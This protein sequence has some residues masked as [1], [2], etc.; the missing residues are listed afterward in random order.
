MRGETTYEMSFLHFRPYLPLLLLRIMQTYGDYISLS[1]FL[2]TLYAFQFDSTAGWGILIS[3]AP[4]YGDERRWLASILVFQ[5]C[6]LLLLAWMW[7]VFQKTM[8]A[9]DLTVTFAMVIEFLP[10]WGLIRGTYL[11]YSLI[12]RRRRVTSY[13]FAAVF[14]MTIGL[15]QWRGV[16]IMRFSTLLSSLIYTDSYAILW[17]LTLGYTVLFLNPD[18]KD[19]SS[20]IPA[21]FQQI[22]P[23]IEFSFASSL[24]LSVPSMWLLL[25]EDMY[26]PVVILLPPL[27]SAILLQLLLTG[28]YISKGVVDPISIS[29]SSTNSGRGFCRICHKTILRRLRSKHSSEFATHHETN[30]SLKTSAIEGCRIC[31]HVWCRLTRLKPQRVCIMFGPIT[32]FY[33]LDLRISII[34]KVAPS[35]TFDFEIIPLSNV[36]TNLENHTGSESSLGTAKQWLSTCMQNHPSCSAGSDTHFRPS[37]LLYIGGNANQVI[38]HTPM[39]YPEMLSYMTLSH[40]WGEA[41]FI[42]LR[43]SDEQTFRQGIPWSSLPQTFKDAVRVARHLGSNYL[44]IDSLCIVQD[45]SRDWVAEA[46]SMGNIYKNALCNIAASDALNSLE[47]CLYPRNYRGLVPERLVWNSPLYLVNAPSMRPHEVPQLYSRAWV[48]QEF[49]L[50][51]RTLD[52]GRDQLYW[53]CDELMASEEFPIPSEIP[54]NNYFYSN[55]KFTHPA[56]EVLSDQADNAN[57]KLMVARMKEWE[58]DCHQHNP[59]ENPIGKP[60]RKYGMTGSPSIFWSKLVA[61]YSTMSITKEEDRLTAIAGV[62]DAFRPFLGEYYAGMWQYLLPQYLLWSNMPEG[63]FYSTQSSCKRPSS[64]RGPTWSWIALEGPI[65]HRSWAINWDDVMLSHVLDVKIVSAQEIHLRIRAP[66]IRLKRNDYIRRGMAAL[67]LKSVN[68]GPS[69]KSRGEVSNKWRSSWFEPCVHSNKDTHGSLILIFDVAEEE[70][71]ARDIVLVA[72]SRGDNSVNG[73]IPHDNG[74]GVFTRS[75]RPVKGLILQDKGGGFFTR[76]GVF[77][78]DECSCF[79]QTFLNCDQV[80]VV[81]L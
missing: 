51:R 81:L 77:Q 33:I 60:F 38:L 44:W 20:T 56:R 70:A 36:S 65:C 11:L 67:G 74:G 45:S 41:Q 37:R 63:G 13:A 80:E 4:I 53:R 39:D 61:Q 9:R 50:A 21:I 59:F 24:L 75:G 15:L 71:A 69:I 30:E 48:F 8:S 6:Q 68:S 35:A 54:R 26:Y 58:A 31:A 14:M 25:Q 3:S 46:A 28:H 10:P 32:R 66:L 27:S 16:R 19:A 43:Q 78:T 1:I 62:A 47:G 12:S 76:V 34:H 22:S 64:K 2:E 40:R 23:R 55:F 29:L 49:L 72:I 7:T 5:V 79:I 42:Q 52:C 17:S 18:Y 57:L 73:Y